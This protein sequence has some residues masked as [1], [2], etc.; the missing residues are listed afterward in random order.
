LLLRGWNTAIP[1]VDVGDDIFVVHDSKGD[2]RRVQ[3]KTALAKRLKVGH[4]AQFNLSLSQL[5]T[6]M[7]PEVTYIFAVR[8]LNHWDSF[9]VIDREILDEEH[10]SYR[11]GSGST[12]RLVLRLRFEGT[13][14]IC[15]ERDLSQYR[16][17]WEAFSIIEH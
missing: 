10:S 9:V 2:L 6:S 13:S 15:K 1:E 12:D 17:N 14:V 16:N 8:L 5:Q 11:L 4:S 7:T 3:V